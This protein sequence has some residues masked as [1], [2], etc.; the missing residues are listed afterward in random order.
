MMGFAPDPR[1]APIRGRS[2]HPTSIDRMQKKNAG[3]ESPA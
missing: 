1:F 2:T 3:P